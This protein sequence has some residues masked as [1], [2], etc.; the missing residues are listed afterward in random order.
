MYAELSLQCQ[1]EANLVTTGGLSHA[2][3]NFVSENFIEDSV[4]FFAGGGRSE[5][6]LFRAMA[7]C[8]FRCQGHTD[9]VGVRNPPLLFCF[10]EHLE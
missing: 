7:L 10:T 9:L 2:M 1:D 8:G 5:I 4:P 6:F 3:L